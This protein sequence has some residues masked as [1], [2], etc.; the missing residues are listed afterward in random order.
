MRSY[1]IKHANAVAEIVYNTVERDTIDNH[2]VNALEL[3]AKAKNLAESFFETEKN[4]IKENGEHENYKKRY[5][6]AYSLLMFNYFH[7]QFLY[8]FLTLIDNESSK[9]VLKYLQER[10]YFEKLDERH[11]DLEG[12]KANRIGLHN[13]DDFEFYKV[14]LQTNEMD[15][16]M[17]PSKKIRMG[18]LA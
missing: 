4:L 2:I 5:E 10:G 13:Y 7:N 6:L 15:E 16:Y 9:R 18:F 17:Q 12:Y 11:K 8:K 3:N 14:N 1:L